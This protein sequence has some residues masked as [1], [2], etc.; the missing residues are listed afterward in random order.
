VCEGRPSLDPSPTGFCSLY[1]WPF[2]NGIRSERLLLEHLNYAVLLRWSRGLSNGVQ[3]AK[4][5]TKNPGVAGPI[6]LL[7]APDAVLEAGGL[8]PLRT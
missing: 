6:L 3:D 7:E 2:A 4:P 1:R 8:G 5:L